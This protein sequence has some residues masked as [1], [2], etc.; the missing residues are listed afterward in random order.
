MMKRTIGMIIAIA[1]AE[2][3]MIIV[4]RS[5]LLK[6]ITLGFL[7]GLIICLILFN[8]LFKNENFD[9]FLSR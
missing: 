9:W 8:I 4:M 1:I 6:G 5:N 2:I 7:L 3:P